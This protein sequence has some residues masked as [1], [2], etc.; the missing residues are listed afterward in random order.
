[1]AIVASAETVY[2]IGVFIFGLVS[3]FAY[4]LTAKW[5]GGIEIILDD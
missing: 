4:N 5:L 1:M 2:G 3:A